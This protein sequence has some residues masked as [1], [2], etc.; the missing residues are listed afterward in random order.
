M[1]SQLFSRQT[2]KLGHR[3]RAT[4]AQVWTGGSGPPLVLLHGAWGGARA[5]WLPVWDTLAR[6]HRVI[7]PE[8][9]GIV[10]D[11]GSGDPKGHFADY[12]DWVVDML[13]ALQVEQAAVVGNSFGATVAWYLAVQHPA[14]CG[15]LALVDGGPP[16][17]LNGLL[18]GLLLNSGLLRRLALSQVRQRVYSLAA[19]KSA[20]HDASKVPD[21]IRYALGSPDERL[22]AQMLGMALRSAVPSARPQQQPVLVMWGAEDRLA[23]NHADAGRA[24]HER[25]PGSRIALIEQ[26]GHLPQVEQPQAFVAAQLPFVALAA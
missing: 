5:H 13:D 4:L 11:S 25:L 17:P 24:L 20:F 3:Q 21:E 7:A 16:P 19:M 10:R 9:P 23:G 8:L 15:A 14:R 18:R 26:A 22:V 12:G 1:N 2:V 6:H